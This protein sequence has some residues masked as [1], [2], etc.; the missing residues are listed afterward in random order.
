MAKFKVI[1]T[2]AG[3][4]S[5]SSFPE[6]AGFYAIDEANALNA[7]KGIKKLINGLFSVGAKVDTSSDEALYA[8]LD[9]LKGSCE[10]YISGYKKKSMKKDENEQW[11]ENLEAEAKQDFAFLTEANA[12][13]EAT[14]VQKKSL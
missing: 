8:S 7:K 6:F 11:V 10:V 1:E 14:K 13:K 4:E 12:K 3:N 9:A 5:R 2:L